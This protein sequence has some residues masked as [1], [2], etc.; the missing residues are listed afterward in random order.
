M[1]KKGTLDP[2][3]IRLR[4]P[5]DVLAVMERAVAGAIDGS[6]PT[7]TVRLLARIGGQSLRALDMQRKLDVAAKRRADEARAKPAEGEAAAQP[8][9][10]TFEER[11][12]AAAAQPQEGVRP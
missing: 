8:S 12:F 1:T 6:I 3:A 5:R 7:T 4:T 11:V 10:P 2:K 9:E